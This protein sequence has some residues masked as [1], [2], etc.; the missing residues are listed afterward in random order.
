MAGKV[1]FFTDKVILSFERD[2]RSAVLRRGKKKNFLL[3][4]INI[5]N[6]SK[7]KICIER[8]CENE[9]DRAPAREI[10]SMQRE[11]K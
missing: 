7:K 1:Q 11:M 3:R 10:M 9:F 8:Q 5:I 4:E 6:F 2:W